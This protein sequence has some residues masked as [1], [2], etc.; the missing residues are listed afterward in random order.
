[1]TSGAPVR[2]REG[3]F[4]LIELLIALTLFGILTTMLFMGLRIGIR[5]ADTVT[6]TIDKSSTLPILHDFLRAQLA[7]AQ[8]VL[9]GDPGKESIWFDGRPDGIDFIG[10]P[11]DALS[12]GGLQQFSIGLAKDGGGRRIVLRRAL[13][14]GKQ[15]QP[16]APDAE[17]LELLADVAS[18]QINYFGTGAG[19]RTPQWQDTW[20]EMTRL[21]SLIRVR[22]T[23]AD[24]R[25]VPDL[26]V[27]VRLSDDSTPEQIL[28][29][30]A[31]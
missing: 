10:T 6:A 5:S 30:N 25:P 4:T 3:G 24:N 19:G 15:S 20:R 17:P 14:Q 2:A 12:A 11:P 8:P 9:R 7:A 23:L 26:I 18:F 1:M 22:I 28:Q 27:A 31:R 29:P 21:P 13:Y 16:E